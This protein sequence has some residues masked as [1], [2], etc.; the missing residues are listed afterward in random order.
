MLR[1]LGAA[2]GVDNVHPH[3]FRRTLASNLIAHGM[4]LPEVAA[5][6][7]HDKIDTTMTYVCLDQRNVEASYRRLA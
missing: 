2:A 6:L 7:G 5:I 1:R 4:Q 3:R